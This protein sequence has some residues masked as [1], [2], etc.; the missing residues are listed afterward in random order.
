MRNSNQEA[1][2]KIKKY[3]GTYP[4][5]GKFLKAGENEVW[6][7][8]NHGNINLWYF[9]EK[10]K[11]T[12]SIPKDF[13][14]PYLLSVMD[15]YFPVPSGEGFSIR[16]NDNMI[17]SYNT[18]TKTGKV[19][20]LPFNTYGNTYT[21][22][23]ED[24]WMVLDYKHVD[25]TSTVTLTMY[26]ARDNKIIRETKFNPHHYEERQMD[27]RS[28]ET[29]VANYNSFIDPKLLSVSPAGK[30]AIY[31]DARSMFFKDL[32]KNNAMPKKLI[33][34]RFLPES[35]EISIAA[36]GKTYGIL[37][38]DNDNYIATIHDITGNLIKSQHIKDKENLI[39]GFSFQNAN[40]QWITSE[41]AFLQEN[42]F[43]AEVSHILNNASPFS[44]NN[45]FTSTLI[46]QQADSKM[47]AKQLNVFLN[48]TTVHDQIIVFFAGHGILDSEKN[49]YF[50]PHNMD[51]ENPQINGIAF[52]SIISN[53]KK[54]PA[55]N[56]LLIL[57]TCHSGNTLDVENQTKAKVSHLNVGARG[58]EAIKLKEPKY[59]VSDIAKYLLKDFF[60]T[61]GVTII[62]AASGGDLALEHPGWGNGALTKSYMEI[63]KKK[64]YPTMGWT[65]LLKNEDLKKPV[66]MDQTFIDELLYEVQKVTNGKQVPD[67][68]ENTKE[69]NIYV[70]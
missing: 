60:F 65:E 38:K 59:K 3:L 14:M 55:R 54:A 9:N 25:S 46:N 30:Y 31:S 22:I 11:D 64:L 17:F 33:S 63:I 15:T 49:Y 50:A 61:S 13:K 18:V 44:F 40:L 62:S 57:D 6:L 35:Y 36:D 37:N 34:D 24:K 58:S 47:I 16:N 39:K 2:P 42:Y 45:V 8:E 29:Y 10:K 52:E 67:L 53:L 48:K 1:A 51:F 23:D 70:W 66:K 20:K 27:G 26:D 7:E 12:L 41:D 69:A 28:K 21:L 56:K 68:R 19:Y 4:R 5:V 43:S 32:T